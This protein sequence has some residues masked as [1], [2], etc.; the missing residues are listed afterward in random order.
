MATPSPD[1]SPASRD[2][3]RDIVPFF[4]A[5]AG[6]YVLNYMKLAMPCCAGETVVVVLLRCGLEVRVEPV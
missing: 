1:G 4:E 2:D 5:V 6:W 3:L